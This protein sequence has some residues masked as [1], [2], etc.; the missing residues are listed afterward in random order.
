MKG[1]SEIT[2]GRSKS[3]CGQSDAYSS[4]VGALIDSNVASNSF[5]LVR[6]IGWQ[7]KNISAMYSLGRRLRWG[8][9]DERIRY[10]LSSR[11]CMNGTQA[12]PDS[13]HSTGSLGKRSGR[14]LMIQLVRWTILHNTNEMACIEMNRLSWPT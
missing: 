8:A 5:M 11:C 7:V 12:S 9:S 6:S 14:P 4:W 1:S 2:V 10:S 13:I 3:Q